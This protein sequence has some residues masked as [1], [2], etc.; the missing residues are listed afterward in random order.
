M[1]LLGCP[2]GK[3]REGYTAP[4]IP[5]KGLLT[6]GCGNG[7]RNMTHREPE[8]GSLAREPEKGDL[9]RELEEEKNDHFEDE[10]IQDREKLESDV[11][12]LG[13]AGLI[14]QQRSQICTRRIKRTERIYVRRTVKINTRR[15]WHMCKPLA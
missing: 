9:A 1:Y 15:T 4:L 13:G 6:W 12:N 2:L 8:K 10:A 11:E 3:P 14:A 7:N 5:H